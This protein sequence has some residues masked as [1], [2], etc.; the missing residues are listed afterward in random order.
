MALGKIIDV[1]LG[2]QSNRQ[3]KK[4][5][6]KKAKLLNY[7]KKLKQKKMVWIQTG[8]KK[9]RSKI[10]GWSQSF[11]YLMSGLGCRIT[12]FKGLFPHL[13]QGSIQPTK[14]PEKFSEFCSHFQ[15]SNSKNAN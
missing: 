14:N 4:I 7:C 9:L 12:H 15:I 5:E 11:T 8:V 1:P 3:P 2:I 10:I 13:N 6:N